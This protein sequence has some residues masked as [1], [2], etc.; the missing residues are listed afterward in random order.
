MKQFAMFGAVLMVIG[1]ASAARAEDNADPTG[2]WKWMVG[3]G[4]NVREMTLKLKLTEGKLTGALIGRDNQEIKIDD[5]AFKDGEV[6]FSVTIERN[7]QKRTTKYT[8][9]LSGDTI[10][11]ST[12]TERDGQKQT[13]A[14]EAKRSKS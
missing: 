1:L 6:S 13:R 12:E 8:G 2:T 7:N 4:D 9:K 11:G 5:A 10:K 3:Q 14:W